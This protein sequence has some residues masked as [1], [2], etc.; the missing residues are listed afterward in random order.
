MNSVI[1]GLLVTLT[2]DLGPKI[3]VNVSGLD[4][5][6]A[7]KVG[8]IGMTVLMLGNS[9]PVL[10]A[11][12]HFKL[13]GPLPVPL[14]FEESDVLE[15]VAI[16][17]NVKADLPTNDGRAT[18]FGREAI[19]WFIFKTENRE[20]IYSVTTLIQDYC[21]EKLKSITKESET[22]NVPFFKE[23]LKEIQQKISQVEPTQPSISDQKPA[24]VQKPIELKKD[25]SLYSVYKYDIEQNVLNPVLSLDEIEKLP[26]FILIDNKAKQINIIMPSQKISERILFFVSQAVSNLN[27]KLRRQYTVRNVN[28][29]YEIMMHM[30]KIKRLQ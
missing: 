25:F 24:P 8:M 20:K 22:E 27:A 17:W 28:D 18:E 23:M 2:D 12:R 4:D 15:T 10:F 26:L 11:Q 9:D 29:E 1:E 30:Q 13:L 21:K 7:H 16:I 6:L 5:T 3:C 19:V 14:E